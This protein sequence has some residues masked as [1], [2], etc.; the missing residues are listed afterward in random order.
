[1]RSLMSLPSKR[2]LLAQTAPRYRHATH[3]QRPQIRDEF[4]AATGYAR[5][6]AIRLLTQPHLPLA[7]ST[8][9]RTPRYGRGRPGGPD[10]LAGR[11]RHLR[12]TS[13]PVS[14]RARPPGHLHRTDTV[15]TAVLTLSPATR[16]PPSMS[17]LGVIGTAVW[18][19]GREATTTAGCRVR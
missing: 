8:R 5:K 10:P 12:Q 1:M 3:A 15:R 18:Y 14:A 2:E 16:A 19:D 9:S 13:R 7:V 17:P 4:V 6:D 11:Q